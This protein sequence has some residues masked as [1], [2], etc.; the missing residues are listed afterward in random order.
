MIFWKLTMS[1]NNIPNIITM[2]R[3]AL[4]PALFFV[5]PLSLLFFV[6]YIACGLSDIFDG[7]IARRMK[8]E[9]RFGAMIDS[10]A[11]VIFI[12][13]ALFVFVPIVKFS[14]W[15]IVWIL[16]IAAVRF[17][18]LAVVLYKYHAF[19]FLHTYANKATGLILFS[20]PLLYGVFGLP[21]TAY[22]IFGVAGFSAV[23]ELAINLT[24]RKLARDIKYIFAK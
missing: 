20:F 6:I 24:S 8:A 7:Y 23:E 10:L 1:K 5:D 9:S 14:A 4:S 11:D 2:I 12:A 13:I 19:A 17:V 15:M 21:A 22:F 18:S 16:G 3:I